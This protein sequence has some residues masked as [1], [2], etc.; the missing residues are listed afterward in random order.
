MIRV[1]TSD[2]GTNS[3]NLLNPPITHVHNMS[4]NQRNVFMKPLSTSGNP[5]L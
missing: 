3:N 2:D 5:C 4:F 1:Q